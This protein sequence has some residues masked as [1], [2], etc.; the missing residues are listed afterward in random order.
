M[1]HEMSAVWYFSCDHHA[2]GFVDVEDA[3]V[4][5]FDQQFGEDLFFCAQ[6]YSVFA[7]NADDGSDWRRLYSALSTALAAYSSCSNLPSWV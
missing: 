6:D 4:G 2:Y 5:A 7:L 1:T 3:S